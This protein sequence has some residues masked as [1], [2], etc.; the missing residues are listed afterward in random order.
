MISPEAIERN[1]VAEQIRFTRNL[2]RQSRYT[3]NDWGRNMEE[4]LTIFNGLSNL[5]KH[6]RRSGGNLVL[7]VGSGTTKGISEV[8]KSKLG[9]GL[10]FRATVLKRHQAIGNNLGY[11]KTF[12]T[13]TE[14]LKG[15]KDSSVGLVLALNSIAYSA[16]PR[17]TIRSIDR[18]LVPGGVLKARFNPKDLRRD[19]LPYYKSHDQF[20]EELRA[21]GYDIYIPDDY[22][23]ELVL[24]V[25]PGVNTRSASDL[26][27]MDSGL[28]DLIANREGYFAKP[29]EPGK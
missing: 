18:V 23:E 7:D 8:A 3:D 11:D 12:I 13:A 29:V 6:V 26:F 10:D 22:S 4:Y 24:A 2:E 17:I 20:S 19:D 15:V 9:E 5:L 21:L 1:S 14:T 27:S 25:K 28:M 16:S